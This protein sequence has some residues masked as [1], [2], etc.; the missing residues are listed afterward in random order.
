[1]SCHKALTKAPLYLTLADTLTNLQAQFQLL[2]I[3]IAKD[4]SNVYCCVKNTNFLQENAFL[5]VEKECINLSG[6]YCHS[7]VQDPLAVLFL[8]NRLYI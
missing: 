1:M 8:D 6:T 2:Q 3:N 4:K 5:V 7:P